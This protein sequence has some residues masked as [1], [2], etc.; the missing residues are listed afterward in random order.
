MA[1]NVNVL[2]VDSV[3][4]TG[5]ISFTWKAVRQLQAHSLFP[6]HRLHPFTVNTKILVILYSLLKNNL[7][8]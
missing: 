8:K 1:E 3:P 7:V 6:V 5:N 2:Y 4:I